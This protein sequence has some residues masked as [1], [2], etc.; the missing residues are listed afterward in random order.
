MAQNLQ[1]DLV[2][3]CCLALASHGVPE[4][5]LYHVEGG[6]YVAALVVVFK[7]FLAV[8][9]EEVIHFLP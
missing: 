8:E 5:R 9:L 2:D 1:Q 3:L 6:F 7:E 4:L